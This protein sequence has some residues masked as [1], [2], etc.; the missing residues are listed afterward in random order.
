MTTPTFGLTHIALAVRDLDRTLA[1]YERLF[2]VEVVYRGDAQLQVSTPGSKDVIAFDLD[3]ENA[4]GRGGIA[5]FGFRLP[6]PEN[7][8]QALEDIDALGASIDDRGEFAPGLPYV[9]VRDPDGYQI[10]IWYE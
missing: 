4:G 3:P 1:F 2:G 7:I 5:H 6:R 10:E 8:E 9:Y